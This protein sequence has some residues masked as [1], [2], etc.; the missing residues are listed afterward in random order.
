MSRAEWLPN[1]PRE[2]GDKEEPTTE[3]QS[4]SSLSALSRRQLLPKFKVHLK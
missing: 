3:T 1:R 2:Q 4:I